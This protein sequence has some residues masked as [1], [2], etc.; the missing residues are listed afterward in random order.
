MRNIYSPSKAKLHSIAL[1]YFSK[2][3]TYSPGLGDAAGFEENNRE[4]SRPPAGGS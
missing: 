3:G 2:M 1:A 4:P